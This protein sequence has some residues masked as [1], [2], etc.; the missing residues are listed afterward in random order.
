MVGEAGRYL[1]GRT[2]P[3]RRSGLIEPLRGERR[4]L[5]DLERLFMAPDRPHRVPGAGGT[6]PAPG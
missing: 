6:S 4:R 5:R 2:D 3:E 1:N